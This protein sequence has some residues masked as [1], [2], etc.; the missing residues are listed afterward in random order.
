[1][2]INLTKNHTPIMVRFDISLTEQAEV[3][4]SG[5]DLKKLTL[6]DSLLR[7]TLKDSLQSVL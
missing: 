2:M 5:L 3:I 6:A 4:L 7:L 1:M